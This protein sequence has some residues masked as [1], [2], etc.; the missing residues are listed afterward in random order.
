MGMQI[1]TLP[2]GSQTLQRV[3]GTSATVAAIATPGDLR[4]KCIVEHCLPEN[5]PRD[6]L[7]LMLREK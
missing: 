4:R 7:P 3:P 1:A 5:R 6:V 2:N